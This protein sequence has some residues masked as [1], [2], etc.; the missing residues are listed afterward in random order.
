MDGFGF[1]LAFLGIF[2]LSLGVE[3]LLNSLNYREAKRHTTPPAK[4]AGIA[5]AF[6]PETFAKSRDYTLERL[7]FDS[8]SLMFAAVLTLI[9][10]FSGALPWLD[11]TLFRFFGNGL[12]H[13]VIFLTVLTMA[14]SLLKLPFSVYSTFRIEGRYGFN[15]MTWNLFWRDSAKQLILSLLLGIPLLYA[16]FFF[17]RNAGPSW[18]LWTFGL[19]FAFQIVMMVIY[20]SLIAPF[21]NRFQP[22][23]E[24]ELKTAIL[25]MARRLRFS[26][27]DI[28][29][30]DGSRRSLH[31]NAY[32]TG[33]GKWRR[34]VLFDTL[35]R[36][37]EQQELLSVL[38]HEIGH[39]KRRHI[40][41]RMV[42]QIFILGA[43]LYL[44]SLALI[45]TP[46]YTA[47]GFNTATPGPAVGIF[48]FFIVFS[49]SSIL[50][51]PFGNW[52]SRRQQYEA[53]AFAVAACGDRE[54]MAQAL[55]K[56]S[57]KNLSNL[58]PHPWYSAFYY[59]HPTLPE[60]LQALSVT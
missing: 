57:K 39:Y 53:D 11:G 32:F 28:Y 3:W 47:F 33:L 8:F 51:A 10:L 52:I 45:W 55:I 21:F 12:H 30:M 19:I 27:A 25:G 1:R 2:T 50:F 26:S 29:V 56:L 46:L 15:T 36:Q 41:K 9:I 6:D 20:P 18:W 58:T 14:L 35:L 43:L 24:G 22:L 44:A 34:I 23:G 48:L 13:D 37:M 16:L 40:Y 42:A 54:A 4:L 7:S 49:S 31:S 5:D 38:A 59:S 60:R 17:L